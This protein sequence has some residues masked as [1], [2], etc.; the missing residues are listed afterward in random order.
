MRTSSHSAPGRTA[1][2]ARALSWRLATTDDPGNGSPQPTPF[3]RPTAGREDLPYR[4][5][6]WDDA[7]TG[8]EQVLAVTISGSI[9]YAAYYAATREFPDRYITLRN[10]DSIV[11]RWN[12]P[13]RA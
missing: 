4:V 11:S 13:E 6:L 5:E 2:A 8:V 12:G 7:K 1:A 10:R 3:G 9:G